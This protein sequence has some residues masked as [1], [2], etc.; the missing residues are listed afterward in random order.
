MEQPTI[1]EL[2][3]LLNIQ[4]QQTKKLQEEALQI[5]AEN[6]RRQEIRDEEAFRAYLR[7]KLVVLYAKMQ[8]S[9]AAETD[10]TS[11]DVRLG[12][13]YVFY[14]SN[15]QEL[16]KLYLYVH[17]DRGCS[18]EE[19]QLWV[20][21]LKQTLETL[22]Y[23]G[24]ENVRS[25]SGTLY[26]L[27]DTPFPGFDQSKH[28]QS[29]EAWLKTLPRPADERFIPEIE[30]PSVA[31]SRTASN[32][33]VAS[34]GGNADASVARIMTAL[35]PLPPLRFSTT[36]EDEAAEAAKVPEIEY[37]NVRLKMTKPSQQSQQ[38]QQP[39]QTPI[40]KSSTSVDRMRRPCQFLDKDI[41][42]KGNWSSRE[43]A[44]MKMP[45]ACFFCCEN[46]VKCTEV[47]SKW[48]AQDKDW[49]QTRK[50]LILAGYYQFA[51]GKCMRDPKNRNGFHG[52]PFFE[53]PR[54]RKWG[55]FHWSS[56]KFAIIDEKTGA[57][58]ARVNREYRQALGTEE[59]LHYC[60]NELGIPLKDYKDGR[61]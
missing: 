31:A 43:W 8:C 40:A 34:E 39:L 57:A 48:T 18:T 2:E 44:N 17:P 26:S 41:R 50:D 23:P 33:S 46:G 60:R 6:Q 37:K 49:K 4:R 13:E 3:L 36:L 19:S 24:V 27:L 59:T 52:F 10:Y 7:E 9:T 5:S 25:L 47:L 51:C 1:E 42:R 58:L 15:M 32:N 28:T 35:P 11:T 56:H 16:R 29:I 30:P 21:V 14:T 53:N 38:L 20:P 54:S 61:H 22:R 12:I 45:M 55:N